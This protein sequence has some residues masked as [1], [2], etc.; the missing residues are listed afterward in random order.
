MRKSSRVE[1]IPPPSVGRWSVLPG[2]TELRPGRH[3][4]CDAT[5]NADAYIYRYM[6]SRNF[7]A[8][9]SSGKFRFS[10]VTTWPDPYERWWH[11]ALFGEDSPLAA[12][13]VYASCWT[14]NARDEPFW[15]LYEDRCE[16]LDAA[17]LPLPHGL[18]AVR[19]RSTVSK[20][21]AALRA[22]LASADAKIFLAPVSYT[23]EKALRDFR[24]R[25]DEEPADIARE[26]AHALCY[27]RS[28]FV[29]ERE[30]RVMW[31]DRE[32][33]EVSEPRKMFK[34][35]ELAPDD[36][37]DQVMVAP[38]VDAQQGRADTLKEKIRLAGFGKQIV[39]SHLYRAPVV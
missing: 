38:V 9:L 7:L 2:D 8:Y 27:K 25:L 16:H 31:I 17:G 39:R 15:R 19:L 26:A 6:S 28:S 21:G 32:Y 13:Q 11:D 20:L 33:R 23:S 34:E 12:A 37:I 30:L 14:R 3:V 36:F 18:P 24:R 22:K 4:L 5:L 1:Y 10:N 29:F 35:I